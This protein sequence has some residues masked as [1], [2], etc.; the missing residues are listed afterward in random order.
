MLAPPFLGA[1]AVGNT[2]ELA[3]PKGFIPVD[4]YY[5]STTFPNIFAVGVAVAA[6]PGP[7]ADP[8]GVPKT[9]NMTVT[10]ARAAARNICKIICGRVPQPEDSLGVLGMD[11]MGDEAIF[12]RAKP[13]LPPRESIQHAK[14]RW[15]RWLKLGFEHYFIW[16]MKHGY[17]NLP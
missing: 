15:V 2:P 5:R 17:A 9:G 8:V 3:N 10:M 11:D 12:L 7:T 1:E 6:T 16:K 13:L 4:Q 14:G